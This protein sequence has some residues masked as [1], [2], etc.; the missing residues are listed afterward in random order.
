MT[1]AE[2]HFVQNSRAEF[3]YESAGNLESAGRNVYT[4]VSEV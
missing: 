3:A 4:V 2:N 1:N